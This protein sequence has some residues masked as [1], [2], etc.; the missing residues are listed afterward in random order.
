[1]TSPKR[2]LVLMADMILH[3]LRHEAADDDA[4][5]HELPPTASPQARRAARHNEPEAASAPLEG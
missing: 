5:R 4:P 3:D 1:M 2:R